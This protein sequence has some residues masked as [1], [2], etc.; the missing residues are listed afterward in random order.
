MYWLAIDREP[1]SLSQLQEDIVSAVTTKSI[2][3]GGMGRRSLIEK[4]AGY[5]TL[6]PVVMGM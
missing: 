1:V 3:G 5:F 2:G 4:H 6:Q